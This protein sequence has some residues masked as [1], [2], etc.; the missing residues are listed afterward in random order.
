MYHQAVPPQLDNGPGRGL[1]GP[2]GWVTFQ[3]HQQQHKAV[4]KT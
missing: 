2:H 3:W 1:G 4:F